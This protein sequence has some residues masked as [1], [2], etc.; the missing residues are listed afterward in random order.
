MDACMYAYVCMYVCT[1]VYMYECMSLI[2]RPKTP[3]TFWAVLPPV[4]VYTYASMRER[5]SQ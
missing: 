5:T 2:T 1:Y 4:H 3:H